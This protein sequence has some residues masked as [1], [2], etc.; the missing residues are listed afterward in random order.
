MQ[1]V[2][3][4]KAAAALYSKLTSAS[5]ILDLPKLL[6][7][8]QQSLPAF[9]EPAG[10]AISELLCASLQSI[11]VIVSGNS[12]TIP[13]SESSVSRGKRKMAPATLDRSSRLPPFTR[14]R[15][16]AKHQR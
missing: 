10:G 12:R 16:W 6:H 8:A 4:P 14:S 15:T 13:L 7:R 5:I 1:A 3:P 9:F 2:K 11:W